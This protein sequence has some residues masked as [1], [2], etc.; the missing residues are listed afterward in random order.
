VSRSLAFVS[1]LLHCDV[2]SGVT[3]ILYTAQRHK[4]AAEAVTVRRVCPSDSAGQGANGG[5][6][7]LGELQIRRLITSKCRRNGSFVQRLI[8]L[9]RALYERRAEIGARGES[10]VGQ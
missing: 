8:D 3:R 5:N 4:Q 2:G 7:G 1:L 10:T 6:L 9:D